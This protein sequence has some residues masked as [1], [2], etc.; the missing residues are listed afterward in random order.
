M[1]RFCVN[2]K[3]RLVL[4]RF[5]LS[6][7]QK[8]DDFLTMLTSIQ[9]SPVRPQLLTDIDYER[10]CS[11]TLTNTIRNID[12][13]QLS[14]FSNHNKSGQ[15]I[16]VWLSEGQ[17]PDDFLAMLM[18]IQTSPV[19]PKLLTD[20]DCERSCSSALKNT[21]RYIDNIQFSLFS[22]HNKSDQMMK[23]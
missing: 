15:M 10:S 9:T 14:L 19:G 1:A 6:E 17:K 11:S 22:N 12:D 4:T 21:I 7:R 18:L 2:K 8:P 3:H 5:W 23:I 16:L 20:L 13:I